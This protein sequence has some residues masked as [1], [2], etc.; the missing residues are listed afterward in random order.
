MATGNVVEETLTDLLFEEATR[1]SFMETAPVV[2]GVATSAYLNP[3][4]STSLSSYPLLVE[5]LLFLLI[6]FVITIL[7]L[8]LGKELCRGALSYLS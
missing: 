1:P 4:A 6:C 7:S 3:F 2:D 5:G 8:S